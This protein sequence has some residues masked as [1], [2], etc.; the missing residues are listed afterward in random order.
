[1]FWYTVFLMIIVCGTTSLVIINCSSTG[2]NCHISA[3]LEQDGYSVITFDLYGR[4]FSDA[5]GSPH[6]QN[7]FVSQLNELL[8]TLGV[9][10]PVNLL[11]YSMGSVIAAAF[12]T[13]YP[14]RVTMS[15]NSLLALHPQLFPENNNN[16][17]YFALT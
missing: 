3:E 13:S 16:D 12:A 1:M 6:T 5:A 14:D 17:M 8:L 2:P 11:G 10:S 4:G 9:S 7:L 15:V